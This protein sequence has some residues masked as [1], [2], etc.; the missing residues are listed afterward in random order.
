MRGTAGNL[1]AVLRINT[2]A[3]ARILSRGFVK[4][5]H[6]FIILFFRRDFES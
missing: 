1:T 5:R 3:P 2:A 4:L 6:Y